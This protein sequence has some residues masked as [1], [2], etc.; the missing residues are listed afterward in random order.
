MKGSAP[1][2]WL[3]IILIRKPEERDHLEDI[4]INDGI[5]LQE[6]LEITNR[7]LSFSTSRIV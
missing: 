5:I 4:G 3:F 2:T 7:I 6:V 1:W